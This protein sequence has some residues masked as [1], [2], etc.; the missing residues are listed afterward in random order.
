ME[1]SVGI[2]QPFFKRTLVERLDDGFIALD[3]MENPAPALRELALHR[4]IAREGK[5][6]KHALTGLFSPKFFAK[7]NLSSHQV[8]VWI[9]AN[10]GYDLY[11]IGGAPFMPYEN[12]NG[13]ERNKSNITPAFEIHLRSLCEAI[14]FDLPEEF[15]RQTNRN[16]CACN[17]WAG[18]PGF[19]ED[20]HGDVVAP[21]F[22][23]IERRAGMDGFLGYARY[24]AQQPV[25]LL[26]LIYERLVDFYVSQRKINAI[27][28]PWDAQS[29]LSMNYHPVI[30][31]YLREMLPLV[32]QIDARGSWSEAEK[33]W[34]RER[35]AAVTHE[36]RADARLRGFNASESLA[37]DPIDFDLPSRYPARRAQ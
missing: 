15:P 8:L 9:A 7:T 29:M 2:Y 21:I 1:P 27:Y 28:Y 26:T 4:Y 31:A 34:L 19:W 23:L 30:I 5:H 11:L 36:I 20:W 25:Y 6:R 22:D 33:S 35:Y 10:P 3:W 13:I 16:Y 17:Y 32:D 37:S 14:S 18:S 12:Y 24:P